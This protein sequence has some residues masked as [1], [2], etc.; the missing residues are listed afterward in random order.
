M[1]HHVRLLPL[2][3]S[4]LIGSLF[5]ASLSADAVQV[6]RI[7][8]HGVQP[9]VC[10]DTDGVVH[11]IY[12]VGDPAHSDIEYVRS[13][14]GGASWSAPLRVNSQAGSTVALGSVRGPHL[15]IGRGNRVHV[16]WMGSSIA[17]PKAPRGIAPMLYS[18]LAEDGKAF[19]PQRNVIVSHPGV[20]GGG[21]VAAD[22]HGNVFVAWHAPAIFKGIEQDRRVWVARSIDDGATFATELSI[23]D[24]ANGA[25]G[26]CGMRIFATDKGFFALYRGASEIVN[27]GMHLV[28]AGT[29]LEHPRDREIDPMKFGAC[30]MSTSAFGQASDPLLAAWE[31]NG[32]VFWSR[33]DEPVMRS[34]APPGAGDRRKHPAVASSA[35]GKVLLA[36]TERTGWNKGGSVAWQIFDRSGTPIADAAGRRDDLP[37]WDLPAVVCSSGGKWIVLY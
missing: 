28:E 12:L 33:I 23:S 19:E 2:L 4:I 25:C 5:P 21:S 37:A 32:Q 6:R 31:T 30:I 15:A 36:W 3:C 29:N 7:P 34:H 13:V 18:R 16:A 26:C 27:R 35:D 20:D 24:P 22:Q 1:A 8:Q 14:D 10:V 17:E 11:L 9:Q